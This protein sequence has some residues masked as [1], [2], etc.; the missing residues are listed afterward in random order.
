MPLLDVVNIEKLKAGNTPYLK[1]TKEKRFS[2]QAKKNVTDYTFVWTLPR[3]TLILW[4]EVQNASGYDSQNGKV[5]ALTRAYG[6]PTLMMSA[7]AAESPLKMRALGYLL[8]LHKYQDHYAW[9]LKHGCGRDRWGGLEFTKSQTV[10]KRHMLSLHNEIFPDKGVRVRVEDLD[11]FPDNSIFADAY[12][13]DEHTAAINR[14]YEELEHKLH[15]PESEETPLTVLLRARQNAELF[16]IPLMTDMTEDFLVEGKSVVIFVNFK[17]TLEELHKRLSQHTPSLIF[18][19][20]DVGDS[21]RNRDEAIR[22]FQADE[23]RVILCMIQAGGVGVN[24]H[25]LHGNHPRV[26]LLSPNYSAREMKQAL[27]RIPRD[28][29][30]S[31]C[32]QYIIFAAGTVEEEACNSVRKKLE[33]IATLNDG[34]LA[35]GLI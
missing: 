15:D 22:R 17:D 18:G 34:D 25:D 23:T 11:S 28:G 3:G 21:T 32:M 30:M 4:D 20:Q 5:L 33:N 2:K 26:S 7:T 9:C 10:A 12:D 24:L 19:G 31:K 16:K 13:M 29:G 8:K 14:V 6:L 35:E 27:G 1:M